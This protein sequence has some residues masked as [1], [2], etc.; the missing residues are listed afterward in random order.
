[1]IVI[2]INVI[3]TVI[4]VIHCYRCDSI[5]TLLLLPRSFHLSLSKL[6]LSLRQHFYVITVIIYR[7]QCRSLIIVISFTV[8][9]T[10]LHYYRYQRHIHCYGC[11]YYQCHCHCITVISLVPL[12]QHLHYCCY[13][14]HF[15]LSLSILCYRTTTFYTM[16]IIIIIHSPQCDDVTL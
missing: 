15:I 2:I 7:Y 14:C 13:Q 12:W 10:L 16:I 5:L 9:T 8:T 11:Y 3:V 6:L 1:M 4:I